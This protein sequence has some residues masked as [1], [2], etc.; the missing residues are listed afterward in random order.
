MFS[1]AFIAHVESAY[2]GDAVKNG[3][4]MPVPHPDSDLDW[5]RVTKGD[6]RNQHRWLQDADL[7][8]WLSSARLNALADLVPPLSGEGRPQVVTKLQ[9]GLNRA[10]EKLE[11][12]IGTATVGVASG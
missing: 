10:G 6:L 5:L 4:C 8:D 1:A 12:L 7:M 9:S 3:L 11:M 2:D